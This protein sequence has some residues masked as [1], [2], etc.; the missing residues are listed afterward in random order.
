MTRSTLH[1]QGLAEGRRSD[2]SFR[3][4][5]PTYVQRTITSEAAE[6]RLSLGITKLPEPCTLVTGG[7]PTP[8]Q[9]ALCLHVAGY[10]EP[11]IIH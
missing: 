9:L 5:P 7:R 4:V 6:R 8:G 3:Y 1:Q 11:N 2:G 10:R